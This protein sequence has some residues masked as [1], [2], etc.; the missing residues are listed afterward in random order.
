[1]IKKFAFWLFSAKAI[2]A[3]EGTKAEQEL[4]ACQLLQLEVHL[5]RS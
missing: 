3:F 1:M 2:S 5:Q 4:F